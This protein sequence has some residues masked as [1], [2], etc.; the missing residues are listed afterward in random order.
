MFSQLKKVTNRSAIIQAIIF[1]I[2]ALALLA[3]TK[4][5]FISLITGPEELD[6]DGTR[7]SDYEGEYV[8]IEFQWVYGVYEEDTVTR[9]VNGIKTGT[10]TTDYGYLIW[11]DNLVDESIFSDGSSGTFYG[12]LA[13]TKYDDELTEMMDSDDPD[14]MTLKG[15]ITKM[16][17]QSLNFFNT[18]LGELFAYN[19]IYDYQN[20][21]LYETAYYLDVNTIGNK[22]ILFIVIASIAALIFILLAVRAIYKL[23]SN[24]YIKDI[25]KYLKANPDDAESQLDS[26]LTNA[27]QFGSSVWVGPRHTFIANGTK[28]TIYNNRKII[29]AYHYY[30]TGK[31]PVSQ[32]RLFDTDKKM[33]TY[34]IGKDKAHDVLNCYYANCPHMV[35]GYEKQYE[36]MFKHNFD[37]FVRMAKN[38]ENQKMSQQ[39]PAQE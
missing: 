19:G 13:P 24:S 15:T 17:S 12:I 16:D 33:H 38:M 37:E 20:T 36:D 8:E 32:I 11:D 26:E 7:L 1:I 35:I 3:I 22:D 34:N 27:Y 39:E 9:T 5:G 14:T 2:I 25:Q 23:V 29:W 10:D 6:T 30:K 4:F 21:D 28:V 18:T 31:N